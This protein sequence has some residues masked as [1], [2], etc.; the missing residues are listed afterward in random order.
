[1]YLLTE[2]AW[3]YFLFMGFICAYSLYRVVAPIYSHHRQKWQRIR[4]AAERALQ[5]RR[6]GG[7]LLDTRIKVEIPVM[8]FEKRC[9]LALELMT[10]SMVFLIS[11]GWGVRLLQTAIHT[12]RGIVA[13]SE[14]DEYRATKEYQLALKSNPIASKIHW[15]YDAMQSAADRQIEDLST[16]QVYVRLHPDDAE[17]YN[18]LGSI[19]MRLKRYKDAIKAFRNGIMLRPNFGV[20]HSNLG[21]ALSAD[22]Q[23]EAAIDEFQRAIAS[24]PFYGPYHNNLGDVYFYKNDLPHAEEEY[25]AAIHNNSTLIQPYWRLTEILT[26]EGRREEAKET[27]KGLLNQSH[28]P[29]DA[30]TISQ[31]RAAIADLK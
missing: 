20:L 21:S 17:G 23:I 9:Q 24:D 15:S 10:G 31:I 29:E 14:R 19:Y 7:E 26:R 28:M 18:K 22:V 11:L 12:H 2:P 30:A 3:R 25:R 16:A 1:M 8:S 6:Q 27:L 5:Q 13:A 4:K